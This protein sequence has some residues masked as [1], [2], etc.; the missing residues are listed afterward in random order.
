MGSL[1]LLQFSSYF[2]TKQGEGCCLQAV[3]NDLKSSRKLKTEAGLRFFL[4]AKYC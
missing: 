2:K 4:S 1:L 3:I